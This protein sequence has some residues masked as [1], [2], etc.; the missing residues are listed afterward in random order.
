MWYF[1][2]GLVLKCLPVDALI[3]VLLYYVAGRSTLFLPA[4][5]FPLLGLA[6]YCLSTRQI[7]KLHVE[8][9]IAFLVASSCATFIAFTNL[10]LSHPIPRLAAN[11]AAFNETM[12]NVFFYGMLAITMSLGLAVYTLWSGAEMETQMRRF[13][14]N[15]DR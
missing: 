12:I 14:L 5:A 7:R 10:S 8:L 13:R 9:P 6:N 4:F 11:Q 2:K 15:A 1:H 3:T